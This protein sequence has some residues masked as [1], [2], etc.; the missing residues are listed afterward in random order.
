MT[1]NLPAGVFPPVPAPT[2]W[3]GDVLDA[4]T[5]VVRPDASSAS[6]TVAQQC[7]LERSGGVVVLMVDGLGTVPL[8]RRLGYAPTLRN[9]GSDP[10]LAQTCCP[11][12]TAAALTSFATGALPAQTSMVG[13]AVR[14]GSGV[15][16]LLNFAPD[17]DVETW[18]PVPTRF[19]TLAA[20]GCEVALITRPR[21]AGSGLTAAAF[22]GARFVGRESLE[23]RFEASLKMFADGGPRFHVVYWSDIDHV[24]HHNGPSSP[25]W[26]AALEDFDRELGKY[27][28]RLPAGVQVV[29]TADHGMIDVEE[30]L[31]LATTPDL[32]DGVELIAGEGRAVHLHAQPGQAQRVVAAWRD[33]LGDRAWVVSR[34]ELPSLIGSGPGVDRVGDAMVL[35]ADR[36]VIVDSRTQSASAIAQK[37]VHG[38]LT[39]DEMSIPLWRLA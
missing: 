11:S 13:Y 1:L 19:E 12:T 32:A 3:V 31:D 38:S 23:Q 5:W 10:V 34:E 37:G 6:P 28:S 24:G 16:T 26:A 15:M 4:A 30:R 9:I 29:L 14:R 22:R 20:E 33:I 39:F 7:G 36:S 17:V 27:L 18:Q 25:E 2:P 21:F 35:M 8:Q